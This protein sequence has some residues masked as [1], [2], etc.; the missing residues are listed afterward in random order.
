VTLSPLKLV[1]AELGLGG[2][3]GAALAGQA[4]ALVGAGGKTSA[5]FG[6]ARAMAGRRVMLTTTTMIRDPRLEEGRPPYRVIVSDLFSKPEGGSLAEIEEALALCAE[7]GPLV[8]ASALAPQG[9]L[10]GIHPER[11]VQLRDL[12]A[13]VLVEAD[14]A[15]GLPIKAPAEWEPAIPPSAGL[16]I[17]SIG[18]GCLGQPLGP[19]QAH[20]P[21]LLASLAGCGMGDPL[22]PTHLARLA[23]STAGLFKGAPAQARCAILLN[24]ADAAPEGLVTELVAL[25]AADPGRAQWVLVASLRDGTEGARAA[26]AWRGGLGGAA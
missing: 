15:K 10:R 24:Q 9:K 12:G 5:L 7:E 23:A 20:R 22:S 4:V 8:L 14:G 6:L 2:G 16:V 25:L 19:G 18:L 1:A 13:L 17:G 11:A 21:E 3:A 26:V